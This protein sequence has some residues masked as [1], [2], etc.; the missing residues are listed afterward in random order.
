MSDVQVEGKR[1]GRPPKAAAAVV[2]GIEDDIAAVN[3]AGP[4]QNTEPEQPKEKFVQVKLIRKY[5][6]FLCY[7][8]SDDGTLS[9]VCDNDGKPIFQSKVPNGEGK[10]Q[11]GRPVQ[12]YQ[13]IM[14]S[15]PEGT[16]IPLPQE[17][18]TRALRLGIAVVT[19]RTFD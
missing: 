11:F 17:E 1:R 3:F 10:D 18:A 8:R 5:V 13:E 9:V 14:A 19:E 7:E 4:V 15:W 6:P 2:T 12:K 16:I